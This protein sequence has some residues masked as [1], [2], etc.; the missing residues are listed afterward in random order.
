MN[1]A[2][3]KKKL[4]K[5][6]PPNTWAFAPV[7]TGR[8]MGGVPDLL[9][10][11]PTLITQEDVGKTVGR[12]VAIEAKIHPNKTTPL[13]DYQLEGIAA[14]SGKAMVITGYKGPKKPYKIE[15][16]KK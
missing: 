15:E 3:F 10:C 16:I 11:V 1:E 2:A 12:F 8:G 14:A 13:Q 5:Q 9:C 7:Q 4:K 6:L